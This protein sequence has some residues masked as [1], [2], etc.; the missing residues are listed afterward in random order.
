MAKNK[1]KNGAPVF[2]ARDIPPA[3]FSM[4][5]DGRKS[6]QLCRDRRALYLQITSHGWKAFPSVAELAEMMDWSQRTAYRRLSEL[7]ELGCLPNATDAKGRK[8]SGERGNRVRTVVNDALPARGSSRWLAVKDCLTSDGTPL[9]VRFVNQAGLSDSQ[10]SVEQD[11]HIQK[12]D[13][14]IEKQ[15]CQIQ[16]QDCHVSMADERTSLLE[17]TE[18]EQ[19]IQPKEQL[20]A[21]WFD[22]FLQD[23]GITSDAERENVNRIR[24]EYGDGVTGFAVSDWMDR[25]Q[26]IKGLAHPWSV[27]VNESRPY[28]EKARRDSTPHRGATE[29]ELEEYRRN[30]IA[31]YITPN[32]E[33][34]NGGTFDDFFKEEKTE[35]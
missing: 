2:A 27:F 34:P 26:T 19:T 17:R 7:K 23:M 35:P 32:G 24:E 10:K 18:K 30:Y 9:L 12:Q 29:E 4:A 28:L 14:Q 20:S 22:S 6:R 5:A 21:G 8:Y 33:E 11:C 1:N 3:S 15:D 31:T 25:P 13:C 16:E